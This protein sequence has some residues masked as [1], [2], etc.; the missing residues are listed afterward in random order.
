MK[1]HISI[2]ALLLSVFA[3]VGLS[4]GAADF[5]NVMRLAPVGYRLGATG[6]IKPS[7]PSVVTVAPSDT[8]IVYSNKQVTLTADLNRDYR[9]IRWQK[10]AV[11]PRVR[12]TADPIEEFGEKSETVSVDFNPNVDWMY[13]A[14]VVEYDP[15]R[16]VKAGRSSFSKGTVTIDPETNVYHRGESVTLTAEPAEGYSFV[17]WSDGN[18]DHVRTLTVDGDI[19]LAAYIE[20]DSSR[21]SFSAGAGAALGMTSKRVTFGSTYGELPVPVRTG[22]KFSGWMDDEKRTVTAKTTVDRVDDHTLYASWSDLLYEIAWDFTGR[23]NGKVDGAGTYAYGSQPTLKAVPYEGSAFT[24]WTDG[25]TLNPRRITVLSNALYVAAFDIATYDVT[26][27]YRDASGNLVTTAPTTVE[28]GGQVDPPSVPEWLEHTF[29]N[30]STEEYKKVTRDLAVEA[31]YDTM[32]YSVAFAYRDW[33]GNSVTTMPQHVVSGGKANPPDRSVVDNWTGNTFR[34]WAPDY[35]VIRQDTLCEA[36]Y[37]TNTYTVTFSYCDSKGEELKHIEY[38]RHGEKIPFD[39]AESVKNLWSGHRFAYWSYGGRAIEDIDNVIA[40]ENMQISAAYEGYARITYAANG[41]EGEMPMQVY[42]NYVGEVQL[43]SNAFTKTGYLFNGWSTDGSDN[44][45]YGDG[46]TVAVSDGTAFALTACWN[47]ITYTVTY[48]KNDGTDKSYVDPHEFTYDREEQ[49][50]SEQDFKDN[51]DYR[52][53][54]DNLGWFEQPVW[55]GESALYSNGAFVKNLASEQ[56]AVVDLYEI[57]QGKPQKVEINGKQVELEYGS[58][59]EK[60]DD[61]APKPGHA[62]S[63]DWTTNGEDAVSFPIVVTHDFN[64]NPL[65]IPIQ[66]AVRFN[67]NGG[68]GEPYVQIMPCGVETALTP[69]RFART[70]YGFANWTNATGTAYADGEKVTDLAAE[71]ETNDLHAVWTV[72]RFWVKFDGNGATDGKMEAQA[73]TYDVAQAL[74]ANAFTRTGYGFAGWAATE[75]SGSTVVY[76]DGEVVSNLTA[77]A[78]ATN[79]LWATWTPNKYTVLIDGVLTEMDYGSD[80][81]KPADPAAREGYTF[82][83][84]TTNGIPVAAWPLKVPLGGLEILSAWTANAY[85]VEFRGPG[86]AYT[87]GFTYDEPQTL[88][89]NRF[90]APEMM[91]FDCWTNAVDSTTYADCETVCNLTTNGVFALYATW[92]E[93][94]SYTV[95]FDGNGADGGSMANLRFECGVGGTLPANGFSRTGYAFDQWTNKVNGAIYGDSATFMED[96]A[97]TNG[98]TTLSALWTANRYWVKFEP[99]G[100][101]GGSMEA[102]AFTYD[103]A[104]ALTANA[105]TRTG[106]G[107]AGW[108]ATED[109]GSTVVYA[110]GE[111]VSN[112]TA[113]ADATNTLWAT[114]TA[115]TYTVRFNPNGGWGDVTTQGFTYDQSQNLANNTFEPPEPLKSFAG[116]ATNETGKAVYTNG[117]AVQNLTAE[118]DGTVNLYAVWGDDSYTVAFDGNGATGG[119]MEPQVFKHGGTDTLTPNAYVRTGCGFANWTNVSKNVYSDGANFTVPATGIGETLYAVWTNKI[120]NCSFDE[121]ATLDQRRK[122]G[123]EIDPLPEDPPMKGGYIFEGWTTNGSDRVDLE[124]FTMPDHDVVFTPLRTPITYTIAFDG[125]GTPTIAMAP[126]NVKYGVEIALPSNTYVL[127]GHKFQGWARSKDAK[128]PDYG[129]KEVVKNLTTKG[130]ETV[131]LYAVWNQVEDPLKAALGFDSDDPITVTADPTDCWEDAGDNTITLKKDGTI[132]FTASATIPVTVWAKGTKRKYLVY[133]VGESDEGSHRYEE[134]DVLER[135]G[136]ETDGLTIE[137]IEQGKPLTIWKS[138]DSVINSLKCMKK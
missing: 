45:V 42:T 110:D 70:G 108:A 58:Q 88:E 91:V 105:F 1:R 133:R 119:T 22:A 50:I 66:Y 86:E 132:T 135:I 61:P 99:N 57:W 103:V 123:E 87:Q 55:D 35:N 120:Y 60:P 71:G 117:A 31:I 18:A 65:W 21:V 64:L 27:T 98:T 126:T 36:I 56:G 3:G 12:T 17:R 15:V 62:F 10:F 114:W 14:V 83:G 68:E 48:H 77:E 81:A 125:N 8:S 73:F 54:Y 96:L 46:D 9:V 109:S 102:Q 63:G 72:N 112:L 76:A 111:V 75:D 24:G 74:T 128:D 136:D 93:A 115:N 78:D 90:T 49:L 16:T 37:E 5:D 121:S 138:T 43:A 38:V 40:T 39:Y 7:D 129:D 95:A 101:D 44:P 47:P 79:T 130:G 100:A 26:F 122:Y 32:T 30:W 69:N 51:I 34:G 107:F 25:V 4:A 89:A 104:Q 124:T 116:W 92:K 20:P 113:E 85:T 13:V 97:P 67:P 33:Q 28:H 127:A 137:A 131:T 106:Y 53:N 19:D 6:D 82:T 84:W 11:D 29:A 41:G 23:G 94:P 2:F 52:P 118:A 80:I 134:S 59:L